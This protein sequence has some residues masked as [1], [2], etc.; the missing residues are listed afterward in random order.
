MGEVHLGG[1]VGYSI[2]INNV[3]LEK[4]LFIFLR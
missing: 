2:R 3:S 1:L 4:F